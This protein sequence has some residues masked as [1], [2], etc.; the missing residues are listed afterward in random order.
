[1]AERDSFCASVSLDV[2]C[3]TADGALSGN[4]RHICHFNFPVSQPG[5]PE[6]DNRVADC[7]SGHLVESIGIFGNTPSAFHIFVV[8]LPVS[9]S[10]KRAHEAQAVGISFAACHFCSL[11]QSSRRLPCR[12]GHLVCLG[13][14]KVHAN[15]SSGKGL[16][17]GAEI[18]RRTGIARPKSQLYLACHSDYI[19]FV[20]R[21]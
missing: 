2:I 19:H 8:R 3:G 6:S 15:V 7:R 20:L 16:R 11:G 9:H 17:C 12:A 1:M 10:A 14:G 4:R 13:N 18:N 5:L 21:D